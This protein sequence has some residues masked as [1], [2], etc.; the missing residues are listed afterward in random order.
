MKER[1]SRSFSFDP[2]EIV[3]IAHLR[4]G[5]RKIAMS[6]NVAV[7]LAM[8]DLGKNILL[9]MINAPELMP[10]DMNGQE[11][12]MEH[13]VGAVIFGGII[14]ALEQGAVKGWDVG[15]LVENIRVVADEINLDADGVWEKEDFLSGIDPKKEGDRIKEVLYEDNTFASF[16]EPNTDRLPR[17]L[18]IFFVEN[19]DILSAVKSV[20]PV[21]KQAISSFQS[22]GFSS[23]QK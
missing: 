9:E 18:K 2:Q 10:A 19:P 13:G 11:L 22:F 16:F 12:I 20:L 5:E 7:A 3:S 15:V 14:I 6:K 17:D 21:Y 1:E 8:Q 4:M 23:S